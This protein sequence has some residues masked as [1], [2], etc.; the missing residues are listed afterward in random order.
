MDVKIAGLTLV[1][2]AA[3]AGS[4]PVAAAQ[5]PEQAALQQQVE[6]LNAGQEALRKEILAMQRQLQ[7]IRALLQA[8][9]AQPAAAAAAP[10]PALPAELVVEG[11]PFKGSPAAPVTIVEF[12]D[13]QCPFCGRHFAQTYG[14]ID[15]EYI[16]TGKVR[17]VFRHFPLE[18]IHP[19][20][21]KAGEAA[22]CAGRQGKFW[23]MHDRL[24]VNQRALMP[25]DLVTHA[26]AVGLNGPAFTACLDGQMTARVRGDLTIGEQAGVAS[27][28]TFFLGVPMPGGKIKVVRK[29]SGA[30]PYANF[31]AAIDS[32]LPSVPSGE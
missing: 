20:A 18:S 31:K 7:E 14:Q 10:Q 23:E 15:K 24:F 17:Y 4:L 29:L 28:P 26:G 5:S 22:E 1:L 13:F 12:S 8:R 9:P 3:V 27:T 11:A 25:A 21:L 32:L 6:K 16:A 2:A 19:Q 30:L